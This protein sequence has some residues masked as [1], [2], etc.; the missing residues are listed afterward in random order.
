MLS[1]LSVGH[2]KETVES[3][4]SDL[5]CEEKVISKTMDNRTKNIITFDN[6]EGFNDN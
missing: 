4:L 5:D 2:I 1:T 3:N 6:I